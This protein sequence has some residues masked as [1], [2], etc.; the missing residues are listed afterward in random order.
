MFYYQLITD[1]NRLLEKFMYFEIFL[2]AGVNI[3]LSIEVFK[4]LSDHNVVSA[5]LKISFIVYENGGRAYF[6]GG[7]VRDAI[8]GHEVTDFYIEVFGIDFCTLK[9]LLEKY[10]DVDET[11]KS[12]CVLKIGGLPI[13]VS[14]PRS[15]QKLG[16]SHRAF[17]V[18]QLKTFDVRA[19]A[20]R[21]DF[22]INSIY[23]DDMMKN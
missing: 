1:R 6:V 10:F 20:G 2:W 7:C 17:E 19:A 14:V 9:S 23:F 13:D 18:K 21:W 4:N 22:T 3:D 15:E 5:A 11:G 16:G 8:L 12:F